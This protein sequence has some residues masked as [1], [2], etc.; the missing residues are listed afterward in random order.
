[1]CRHRMPARD[2]AGCREALPELP[3]LAQL[4]SMVYPSDKPESPVIDDCLSIGSNGAIILGVNGT[5]ERRR[6]KNICG[7]DVY[8]DAG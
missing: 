7:K 6:S 1:M 3:S 4:G 8:R 2:R 5:L